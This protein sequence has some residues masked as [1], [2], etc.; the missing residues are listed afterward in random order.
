MAFFDDLL[1]FLKWLTIQFA[2]VFFPV[3]TVYSLLASYWE[4][5]FVLCYSKGGMKKRDFQVILFIT[6]TIFTS[7]LNGKS[8]MNFYIFYSESLLI[9]ELS[10]SSLE[11][12]Y[13]CLKEI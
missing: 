1:D 7:F 8:L 3:L 4:G 9:L 12:I 11:T 5:R 13:E 10:F 6:I 2:N